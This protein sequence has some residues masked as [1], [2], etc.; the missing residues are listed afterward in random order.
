VR[1]DQGVEI[2]FARL[3]PTHG[4]VAQITTVYRDAREGELVSGGIA[5]STSPPGADLP[6]SGEV[7]GSLPFGQDG[8]YERA[9]M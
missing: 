1:P 4:N 2:Q 7:N 3:G 9:F 5:N 6:R 8:M